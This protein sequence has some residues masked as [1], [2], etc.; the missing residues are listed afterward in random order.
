MTQRYPIDWPAPG[1][2][3]TMAHPPG[4]EQLPAA[5]EALAAAGTEVLVS[6]LCPDE[7]QLLALTEQPAAAAAAGIEFVNFP[8]TDRG[9]PAPAALPA[10]RALADRLAGEVRA[11]RGVVTHCWAGIGRSSLLAGA[12]LVRLGASPAQAW[13]LIRQARGLPVP[14]LAEQEQWLYAFAAARLPR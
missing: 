12:T 4:G 11:G 10:V 3:A 1:E 9:V 6:A 2:L 7:V 5:L 13:R 14:D 8:I